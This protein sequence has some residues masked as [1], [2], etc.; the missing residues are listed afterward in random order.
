MIRRCIGNGSLPYGYTD[1][2]NK[3]SNI[4]W[5]TQDAYRADTGELPNGFITLS[6]ELNNSGTVTGITETYYVVEGADSKPIFRYS[7]F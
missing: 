1:A 4:R 2:L 7:L 6:F 5:C 3:N